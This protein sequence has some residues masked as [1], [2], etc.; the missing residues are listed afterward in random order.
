M[1]FLTLLFLLPTLA[2]AQ[3]IELRHGYWLLG[4]EF[5]SGKHYIV[6]GRLTSHAPAHV[7]SVIDLH[8]GY[9]VPPYGEA[10]NHNP[11]Y[12]G[13]ESTKKLFARYLSDGVFYAKNPANV[14]RGR[15][16]LQF[17]H[18]I[19]N[20]NSVDVI[21]SNGVLTATGGHPS[22]LWRRNV[23]R[24]AMLPEDGDGGFMW[25]IDTKADLDAKWPR[26]LAGK[27]DF[28]KTILVHSEEYERRRNDSTYFNWRGLDPKLLPEIARRAHAAGLRVSAHVET[29]ADFHN[30][31]IAK[32][33]EI[34]H[35]PGFRG[36]ETAHLP[37]PQIFEIDPRDARLAARQGTIVVTTLNG[38]TTYKVDGPDSLTRRAFDDLARKNL[39]TLRS[40]GVHLAIGS[41]NYRDDSRAEVDY[42]ST[43]GVFSPMEL[44]ELWSQAT[45]RAIFPKRKVGCLDDGCEAS[46]L[47]LGDFPGKG[48]SVL[49]DLKMGVKD[50]VLHTNP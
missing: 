31:L 40:A 5:R 21:F 38:A 6:H 22:G 49:H 33:D 30:A 25:L 19:D 11:D 39:R 47:V 34:N 36:D 32:V 20:P 44:L 7:D 45:P 10:H 41:D 13:V 18:L 15:D 17:Y 8:N 42:L 2:S 23:Q 14:P 37:H 48:F 4:H 26:I 16:S 46:F 50:G 3:T 1:R 27:P 28:I 12:S 24:G 29:A 43:L 35:I 9:V